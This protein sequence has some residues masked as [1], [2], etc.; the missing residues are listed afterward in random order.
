L[1]PSN[2][3]RYCTSDHKRGPILR[4]ITKLG[5]EKR[6]LGRPLRILQCIGLRA[7]E[8]PARSKLAPFERNARASNSLRAVDDWLP[9]HAWTA[10]QVWARIKASGVRHHYAYDLGMPRLSCVFCIF[11]PEAA[12]LLAGKH[13]PELLAEYVAVEERIGHTFRANLPLK[14]IQIKL[15]RDAAPAAVADWRM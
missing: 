14:M 12:L 4:A 15:Q 2:K 8:S 13:N 10:S 3:Q 11:A 5:A 9:I 6:H 7:D 1:W